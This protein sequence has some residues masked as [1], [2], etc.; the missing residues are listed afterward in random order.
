MSDSLDG[1]TAVQNEVETG[2]KRGQKASVRTRAI[3]LAFEINSD[4]NSGLLSEEKLKHKLNLL[5]SLVKMVPP[6]RH[7]DRKLKTGSAE[8]SKSELSKLLGSV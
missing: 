8:S 3:A 7:R 4:I 1:Q 2:S 5:K 6:H